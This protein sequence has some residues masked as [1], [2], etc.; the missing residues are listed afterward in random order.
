MILLILNSKLF[1]QRSSN[2]PHRRFIS[3]DFT[4]SLKSSLKNFIR[5]FFRGSAKKWFRYSTR[6]SSKYLA[7]IMSRISWKQF[8]FWLIFSKF[9]RAFGQEFHLWNFFRM[10]DDI[11]FDTFT[12]FFRNSCENLFNKLLLWFSRKHNPVFICWKC[13]GNN[14]SG[15]CPKP[16]TKS[17]KNDS[18]YCIIIDNCYNNFIIQVATRIY[19][20]A[21][22]R[23]TW[24]S[25]RILCA[26]G[27]S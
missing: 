2:S 9:Y 7:Q 17:S 15:I 13:C 24:I 27:I 1:L 26:L 23:I 22:P 12:C 21:I 20:R 6:D 10:L 5:N 3:I 18:R 8:I 11:A 25:S 4:N 14:H 16:W 19:P